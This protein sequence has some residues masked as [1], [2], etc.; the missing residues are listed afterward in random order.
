MQKFNFSYDS[1]NDDLFLFSNKSKSKGSVEMGDFIF[2]YNAK[3]EL[4]GIQ[5][6]HAS[7]ILNEF[8]EEKSIEISK[9]LNNLINCKADIKIKNNLLIVKLYL[10]SK[11]KEISPVLSVPSITHS[12]PALLYS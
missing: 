4:V 12:S 6:M 3:A 1:E 9:L 10:L 5:I 2:D 7:K 8:V 11:I